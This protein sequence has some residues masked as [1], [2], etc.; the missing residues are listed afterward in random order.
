MIIM[1]IMVWIN[2]ICAE[3]FKR[4]EKTIYFQHIEVETKQPTFCRRHLQMFF[5]N[6][7]CCIWMLTSIWFVL[8]GPIYNKSELVQMMAWGHAIFW[9][10]GELF[11]TNECHRLLRLLLT[12]NC[13]FFQNVNSFFWSNSLWI[14][15]F[16]IKL[17]NALWISK[18]WCFTNRAWEDTVFPAVYGLKKIT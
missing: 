7:N 10:N 18:D 3:M 12:F 15:Y 1:E 2:P 5:P 4:T 11:L 16:C 9:A 8:S 14:R 13:F 17:T 6:E